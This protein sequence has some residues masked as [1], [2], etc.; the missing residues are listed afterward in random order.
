VTWLR[1][2]DREVD[3]F[4]TRPGEVPL[5]VQVCMDTT[6]DATWE[7]EVRALESASMMHTDA[8]AVLITQDQSP[9]TRRLPQGVQWYSAAQWLLG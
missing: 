5:L 1:V 2:D 7:R 9:P 8:V 4:A 6:D 3:F